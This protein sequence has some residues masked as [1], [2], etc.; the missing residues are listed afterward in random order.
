M[1]ILPPFNDYT[2]ESHGIADLDAPILFFG[3]PL[4]KIE[5]SRVSRF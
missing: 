5:F 4:T 1:A 2:A 3:I